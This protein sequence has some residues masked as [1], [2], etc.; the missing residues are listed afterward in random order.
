MK[1]VQHSAITQYDEGLI[2]AVVEASRIIQYLLPPVYKRFEDLL[3]QQSNGY[4]FNKLFRWRSRQGHTLFAHDPTNK[5]GIAV[6]RSDKAAGAMVQI[7]EFLAA[8]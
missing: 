1:I 2:E 6:V 5:N 7:P 3:P 8:P 4:R